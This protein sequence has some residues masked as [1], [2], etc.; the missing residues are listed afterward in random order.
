MT[1]PNETHASIV[2]MCQRGIKGVEIVDK[3]GIPIRT[4]QRIVKQF[5]EDGNFKSL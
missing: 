2:G 5:K 4:I 3:V 1:I